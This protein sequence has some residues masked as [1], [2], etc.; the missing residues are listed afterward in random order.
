MLGL[1]EHEGAERV[2]GAHDGVGHLGR[3]AFLQ[4][5]PRRDLAHHAGQLGQA[6]D[7]P[8]FAGDVGHVGHPRE[9]QQVVLADRVEVDVADD[10]H[11]AMMVAGHGH[12]QLGRV[13]GADAREDVRVHVGHAARRTDESGAPRVLA[14]AFEDEA[15]AL[16]YLVA[17][18]ECL[19]EAPGDVRWSRG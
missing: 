5:R 18:H 12:Q 10:H 6:G 15:Y 19:A 7:A 13:R 8:V 1:D 9:R 14:D 2:E 11:L 4:L 3:D 16:L 17:I